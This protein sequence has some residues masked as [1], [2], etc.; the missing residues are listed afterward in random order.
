MNSLVDG[1]DD[2]ELVPM[3]EEL[4]LK[5]HTHTYGKAKAKKLIEL[6][7]KEFERKHAGHKQ[8]FNKPEGYMKKLPTN[9]KCR[10]IVMSSEEMIA[11]FGSYFHQLGQIMKKTFSNKTNFYYT[12]GASPKSLGEFADKMSHYPVILEMDVSNWD[13]AQ[14]HE[15]LERVEKRFMA[16][17][18]S[19]WPEGFR[20]V[21][22]Y[23]CNTVA[24]TRD[25][26]V[27]VSSPHGRRS[28]DLW[29]SLGNSLLN[30]LYVLA[31]FDMDWDSDIKIMVQGDDNVVALPFDIDVE[32]VEE[33]YAALGMS[34]SV[35]KH[36]TMTDVE[37]CSGTF[38]PTAH[39]YV[40]QTLPFRM[41]CRLG[42]DNWGRGP[43][44]AHN[45][46]LGD[47]IGRYSQVSA[48]PV[49]STWFTHLRDDALSKGIKRWRDK[50]DN[51]WSVRGG[52]P[53]E[54]DDV[55]FSHFCDRYQV[56]PEEVR[57]ITDRLCQYT[58]ED[59]PMKLEGW[60]IQ[61][62]LLVDMNVEPDL[63]FTDVET[64]YSEEAREEA[65]KLARARAICALNNISLRE[66]A[67][68]AATE[69]GE[70]EVALGAPADHVDL[71]IM[72]T[73]ASLADFEHGVAL[74]ERYN[75]WAREQ[76]RHVCTKSKLKTQA[77]KKKARQRKK[78]KKALEVGVTLPAS[79]RSGMVGGYSLDYSDVITGLG[80]YSVVHNTLHPQRRGSV[81]LN[82]GIVLRHREFIGTIQSSQL[83]NINEYDLNPGLSHVF[84]WLA[85][86]AE[87][88]ENYEFKGLMFE[89]KPTTAMQ[90]SVLDNGVVVMSTQYDAEADSFISRRE[91]EAYMF[92]TS[93]VPWHRQCHYVEC[94]PKTKV[95][96][97]Q[98]IRYGSVSSSERWTDLGRL[99]VATQG[100]SADG[101]DIGELWVEYHIELEKPRIFPAGYS[102][103]SYALVPILLFADTDPFLE[104]G[105]VVGNLE[106]TFNGPDTIVIGGQQGSIL[107]FA[108]DWRNSVAETIAISD[109]TLVGCER[110]RVFDDYSFLTS[111]NV[112]DSSDSAFYD[113][114]LEITSPLATITFN[115]V[116]LPSGS[117]HSGTLIISQ[118]GAGVKPQA[119]Q[120]DYQAEI[121]DLRRQVMMLTDHLRGDMEMKE[122]PDYDFYSPN[123]VWALNHSTGRRS[124]G[125]FRSFA[126]GSTLERNSRPKTLNQG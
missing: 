99:T 15:I 84:P 55:S 56:T 25:G 89:F 83:F 23:W 90:T 76:G 74:H 57:A 123:R 115:T 49:F 44:K 2:F 91:M 93:A 78:K 70:E 61:Q 35:K 42:W 3:S 62:G 88:Y 9:T 125:E 19:G 54:M 8:I 22:E 87:G 95:L 104:I 100:M 26:K 1:L 34:I 47:F 59:F 86:I 20:F 13:G 112:G 109:P 12:S 36:Y 52:R 75:R 28:G 38:W 48:L 4:R 41:L 82:G 108:I 126:D 71:H 30:F 63:Q 77:R 45:R 106:L 98:Y 80:T 65:E 46:L 120:V 43:K 10:V 14:H 101:D 103:A 122:E 110:V 117:A 6:S 113:F 64:G 29:T 18:V 31:C 60:F 67:I 85:N 69:F 79:V 21:L 5:L 92:T 107:F 68:L 105:T 111:S 7:K 27:T 58:I 96:E 116:T 17:K 40:W 33:F 24:A 121:D 39:G 11:H 114:C 66:A 37:F 50:T 72:F 119:V 97:D 51:P 32:Y 81:A 16:E 124:S 73:M 53:V 102:T 118:V 94:R